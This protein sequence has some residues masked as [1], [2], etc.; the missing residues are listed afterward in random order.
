MSA[1]ASY[2]LGN[3]VRVK[4]NIRRLITRRKSSLESPGDQSG[5]VVVLLSA[6]QLFS[7]RD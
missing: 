7:D 1:S 4:V 6:N 3:E 5:C 2:I